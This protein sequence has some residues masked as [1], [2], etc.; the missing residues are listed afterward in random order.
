VDF[1]EILDAWEQETRRAGSKGKKAK[2]L[3]SKTGSQAKP[4][5]LTAWLRINGV[6]DKD[7]EAE[8]ERE[9]RA[10]DRRRR[11]L[12]KKPDRA[13]DLHGMTRD[14]AW[15]ALD[16]F[17]EGSR[18]QGLEKLLVVHGKGNHSSG[19]AVLKR[20]VR[21]FIERCPFAGESGQGDASAGGSGVTWVLLKTPNVPGR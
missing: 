17:F 9:E 14:E 2:A 13:I 21:E 6:Q 12:K 11:L 18:S 20:T 1:G 16:S 5:P 8:A 7:A 10:G 4:D 19:E 3:D 15:I